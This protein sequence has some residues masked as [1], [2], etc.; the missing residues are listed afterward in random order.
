MHTSH[1]SFL[2]AR[3]PV[4]MCVCFPA[5]VAFAV[6]AVLFSNS[7]G[8]AHA[9]THTHACMHTRAH[10]TALVGMFRMQVLVAPDPGAAG[11]LRIHLVEVELAVGSEHL[12]GAAPTLTALLE[13]PHETLALA[14][15]PAP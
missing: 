11:E 9:C 2:W 13:R 7:G 15:P 8:T 10:A 4:N 5:V 6:L 3:T 1:C 14:P 12:A